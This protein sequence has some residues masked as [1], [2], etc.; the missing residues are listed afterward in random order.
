MAW[1]L[2]FSVSS[3]AGVAGVGGWFCAE[4]PVGKSV[5][6]VWGSG[7]GWLSSSVCKSENNPNG[8]KRTT[9]LSA[10]TKKYPP[11]VKFHAKK[12]WK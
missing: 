7:F 11:L 2:V 3:C 9:S 5:S 10:K 4:F 8:C 6:G 12:R 1:R